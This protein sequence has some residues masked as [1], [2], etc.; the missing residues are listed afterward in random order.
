M[1]AQMQ[2]EGTLPHEMPY[3]YIMEAYETI[4]VAGKGNQIHDKIAMK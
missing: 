2:Y 3:E 4:R 1:L